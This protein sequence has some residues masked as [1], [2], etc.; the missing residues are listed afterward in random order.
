MTEYTYEE[1]AKLIE[2]VKEELKHCFQCE[3]S[4][5]RSELRY[6][7]R[8]LAQMPRPILDDIEVE[9]VDIGA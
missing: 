8:E 6:Y 2:S 4:S 9:E 3:M 7:K 1:L 5:L